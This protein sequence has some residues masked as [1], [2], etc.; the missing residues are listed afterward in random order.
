ML[1]IPVVVGFSQLSQYSTEVKDTKIVLLIYKD[2]YVMFLRSNGRGDFV[3]KFPF[4]RGTV[5]F[6]GGNLDLTDYN[7]GAFSFVNKGNGGLECRSGA[8]FLRT[9]QLKIEKYDEEYE[10]E[11]IQEFFPIRDTFVFY[12]SAQI[13]DALARYH[14]EERRY[15]DTTCHAFYGA[16]CRGLPP[17]RENGDCFFVSESR[18]QWYFLDELASEGTWQQKND[19]ILLK[20]ENFN[21]VFQ[22]K[23]KDDF[24]KI[25]KLL[26]LGGDYTKVTR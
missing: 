8:L 19:T 16:Y 3:S 9:N 12:D 7:G 14:E 23:K 22:L 13:M 1:L 21:C 4:S 26:Q 6:N 10:D 17:K 24:L 25:I 11:M 18:Y 20:D 15:I 2:S 5:R